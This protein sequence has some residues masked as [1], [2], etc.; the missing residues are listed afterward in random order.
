MLYN[1]LNMPES[2]E[3]SN[4]FIYLDDMQFEYVK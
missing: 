2:Y 1:I 4:K 3:I